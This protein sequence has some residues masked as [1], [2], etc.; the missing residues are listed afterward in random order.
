MICENGHKASKFITLHFKHSQ[1]L[2]SDS[3]EISRDEEHR[4]W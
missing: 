4:L 3:S 2:E 1:E